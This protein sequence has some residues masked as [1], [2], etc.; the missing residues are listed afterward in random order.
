MTAAGQGHMAILQWLM[1]MGADMAIT[2]Y[3][4]E[5]PKDVARRFA[6]LAAVRLLGDSQGRLYIGT[7]EASR[8]EFESDVLIRF[9]LK[10]TGRFENCRFENFES[11][12]LPRLQSYHKQHSLFNDKFQSFQHCYWDLY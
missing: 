1:E 8:F 12:R 2:N 6:R 5:T 10:V 4:N 3:A 11:P 9:D 7:C